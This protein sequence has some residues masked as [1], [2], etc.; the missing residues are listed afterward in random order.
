MD[1]TIFFSSH[2]LL[3]V[4]EICTAIG[5]IEAGK[6]V[7]CGTLEE[8]QSHR[9]IRQVRVA[10]TDRAEQALSLLRSIPSVLDATLQKRA[11]RRFELIVRFS[12]DDAAQTAILTGLMHAGLPVIGFEE[13]KAELEDVFMQVTKGIVS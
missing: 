7:S 11:R 4:A 13:T 10:L 3:E 9:R 8:I 5:I 2:I 1:K 12:G 6:L